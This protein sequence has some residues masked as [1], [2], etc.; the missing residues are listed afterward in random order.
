VVR[1]FIVQFLKVGERSLGKKTA[2]IILFA[3]FISIS[4][5]QAQDTPS[6]ETLTI[7]LWPEY[8]RPNMLVIYKGELSPE[9]SLPA[10]VTL[11]MP[12]EA[13]A[14]AVVAVGPDANSV[15]DAVFETQVMGEWIEVSFIAT[16]PVI[17][18]EYYDPRLI[19][20]GALRSFDFKWPGDYRVNKLMLQA[21]QPLG[22]TN[23]TVSPLMGRMVQDQV[24]FSYDIIDVGQLAQGETFALGLSYEKESDALS[25]ESLQIQPSAT[26][27]PGSSNL[28]SLDQPWIWFLIA[29]GL[30][31]I[32]GGGYW[33]WRTGQ[34]EAQP[35]KKRRQRR[36]AGSSQSGVPEGK[37]VYCH[38]CG[39]RAQQ[40]DVFCRT[41]G[42]RLR[43]D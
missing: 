43:S 5:A 27:T 11:R 6:F 24:G 42:T 26:I 20:D 7:D 32:G 21:Q 30:V 10:E 22:A 29:L 39:K 40:G 28:F 15:A 41:C 3:L 13:G 23:L 25:V 19:K 14:P 4:T 33:Y 17:Q 36:S 31:L 8:D 16:T 35:Q 2:L 34:D 12:V 1:F 9:V 38:Q 37:T 18:F